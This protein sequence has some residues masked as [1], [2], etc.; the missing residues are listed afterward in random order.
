M[1]HH[2]QTNELSTW[3]LNLLHDE[4]IDNKRH[5]FW[6]SNSRPHE[7]QLEDKRPR[8]T[9]ECHLEEGKAT[10]PTQGMKSGKSKQ[11]DKEE[12]GMLKTKAKVQ[13]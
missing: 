5:K 2:N 7:V 13:N 6:S 10:K 4:S 3:F 9:Q 1:T 8:K 11:N 12:Q